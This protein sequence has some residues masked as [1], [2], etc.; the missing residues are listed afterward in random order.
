MRK[1]FFICLTVMLIHSCKEAEIKPDYTIVQGQLS[2]TKGGPLVFSDLSGF[3]KTINIKENG[4]FSDTLHVN[5]G[6]FMAML[7]ENVMPMYFTKGAVIEITADA[8]DVSNTLTY[9]GDN[10]DLNNYYA[11]KAKRTSKIREDMATNLAL[12]ENDYL[13]LI[14]GVKVDFED[15]LDKSVTTNEDIKEK[16][17]RAIEYFIQDQLDYYVRY[18]GNVTKKDDFQVSDNFKSQLKEFDKNNLEDF[19]YSLDYNT[20]VFMSLMQ[21]ASALASSDS[22]PRRYAELT[23][24]NNIKNDTLRELVLHRFVEMN[25]P[26]TKDSVRQNYYNKYL[27]LSKNQIKKEKITELYNNLQKLEPGNPSPKFVNYENYKGGT[28]SLDDFKGKYV[29]IDVWATWCGPCKAQ[30]PFLKEVEA[31]Y[32]NKNIEFI[33]LSV[34][35][36]KD[37]QKWKKM[38][39]ENEMGGVQLFADAAFN[40]T[41][42]KDYNIVGIPQ[43]ILLDPEGNIVNS[44]APRPSDKAL[45]DLF[46]ELGI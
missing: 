15:Q 41:F 16:E 31:K 28:T 11:Y 4:A 24:A 23:V 33:S 5:E 6:F 29:Y 43:F 34:D 37:H 3:S 7:E 18:H 17:R 39:E 27:S 44:N 19:L 14:N 35:S 20:S 30:I 21:S 45:I 42:I 26:F 13:E 22:I 25:L 12:E 36:Q 38:I 46:S 40:S 1:I 10:K 32:H 8:K 2:N 9:T